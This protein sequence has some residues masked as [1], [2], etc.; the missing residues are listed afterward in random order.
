MKCRRL[1][2]SPIFVSE[3]GLGTMNFGTKCD[4]ETSL[5]ILDKSFDLGVNFYD[6]AEIYPVPST[7]KDFGLSESILGDWV[8]TKNRNSVIIST[9]VSGSAQTWYKSPARAGMAVLDRVQVRKALEGSLKRLNTDYIDVYQ[10]H[11]PD[12]GARLEDLLDLFHSFIKE[13]KVRVLGCS[14]ETSWGLMKALWISEANR[15]TRFDVIQ[16]S[17][18]FHNRRFEDELAEVC[19]YEDVSLVAYAPLSGGV[20][21]GKYNSS[22]QSHNFRFNHYSQGEF[23]QKSIASRY[24]NYKTLESALRFCEIAQR[25]E[26]PPTVLALAW[27]LQHDYLASSLIGISNAEQLDHIA[28]LDN[29]E[30]SEDAV[31]S[32]ETISRE[33]P[34][35]MEYGV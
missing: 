6:S 29:Y 12:H 9:K 31:S 14:N 18:S 5:E 22:Q 4:V 3:I 26:V 16:N 27:N 21:T 20:L 32:L 30:I 24:V 33:M 8:R 17:Y 19:L 13:G 1:G 11:W 2:K 35:P 15:Y 7:V 23:R 28:C 34:Y 25:E 10:A